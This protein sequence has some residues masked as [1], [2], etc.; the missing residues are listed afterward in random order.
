MIEITS[1]NANPALGWLQLVCLITVKKYVS[2]ELQEFL[3]LK[4]EAERTS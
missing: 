4:I 1:N 3:T 2:D